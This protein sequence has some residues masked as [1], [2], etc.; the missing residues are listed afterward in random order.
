MVRQ[1]AGDV[2]DALR[3][4]PFALVIII[5]NLAFLGASTWTMVNISKAGE[6]RDA[7]MSQLAKDCIV[8]PRD[9]R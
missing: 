2:V 8:A 6:R 7:L 5:V 4:H 9:S 1:V 3:Q